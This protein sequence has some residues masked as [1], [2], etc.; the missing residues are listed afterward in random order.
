[1]PHT[2]GGHFT[3]AIRNE[4]FPAQYELQFLFLLLQFL[5]LVVSSQEF[6]GQDSTKTLSAALCLS[7]VLYFL[8]PSHPS[9]PPTSLF[10]S[11]LH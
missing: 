10:S 7:P 9:H 4:L 11:L 6:I 3:L 5:F 2:L 1:M 8:L